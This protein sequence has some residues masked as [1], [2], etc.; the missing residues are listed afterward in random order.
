MPTRL[1]KIPNIIPEKLGVEIFEAGE[2]PQGTWTEADLDQIVADYDEKFRQAQI[3]KDHIQGGQTFGGVRR[4]YR[5]GSK[6]LADFVNISGDIVREI[7]AHQ[8]KARSVE[9]RREEQKGNRWYL[10][11]VTMLGALQPAVPGMAPINFTLHQDGKV[12]ATVRFNVAG[13]LS[14]DDISVMFD[15]DMP[16]APDGVTHGTLIRTISC[17][18]NI[19]HWHDCFIDADG[20]GYTGPPKRYDDNW[21]LCIE[22]GGHQHAIAGGAIAPASEVSHTH[23]LMLVITTGQGEVSMSKTA[24]PGDGAKIEVD[25]VAFSAQQAENASLKRECENLRAENTAIKAEQSE[26]ARKAAFAK[27]FDQAVSEGRCVPAQR[28]AEMAIYMSLPDSSVVKFSDGKTDGTPASAYLDAIKLRPV[29]IQM[30]AV[31]FDGN[32]APRK[33][34]ESSDI[35]GIQDDQKIKAFMDKNPGV[36]YADAL[37]KVSA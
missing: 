5:V 30:G 11:A 16:T 6:L 19:A 27:A 13:A 22:D 4:I 23:E 25:A 29:V 14:I 15:A 24:T 26:T 31:G 35:R 1:Q 2:Y 20:N 32:G 33:R 18:E 9:F 17:V 21:N 7:R 3:T 10:T 8:W 36:T 37:V 12:G 28:D 34:D